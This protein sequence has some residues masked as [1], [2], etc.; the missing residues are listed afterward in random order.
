MKKVSLPILAACLGGLILAVG[1]VQAQQRP[2][3]PDFS[4]MADELGVS[5]TALTGC[6]GD[7]PEPGQRPSRPD[8]KKIA[9]CLT[10]A[11]NSVTSDAVDAALRA[12]APP[13]P[14]Q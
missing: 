2:P 1:P 6:L 3:M 5:E 10:N 12:M 9:T 11:G 4:A 8:A 14:G 7:K 13:P